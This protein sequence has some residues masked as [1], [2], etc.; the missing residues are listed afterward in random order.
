MEQRNP[1]GTRER[2]R[3]GRLAGVGRW[4]LHLPLRVKGNYSKNSGAAQAS[5]GLQVKR[6]RE[7][8]GQGD[9]FQSVTRGKQRAQVAGQRGRIARNVNESGRGSRPQYLVDLLAQ[10]GA[11]RVYDD[12]VRTFSA[13]DVQELQYRQWYG[14]AASAG[15]V[16]GEGGG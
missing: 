15:K 8:V 12:E 4:P 6:L 11:R 14:F 10:P 16:G 5:D 9:E 13:L 3:R 2:G 7:K 1:G